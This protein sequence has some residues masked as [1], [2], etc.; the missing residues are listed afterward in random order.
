[1]SAR[2]LR[3]RLAERGLTPAGLIDDL[4]RQ[5]AQRYL[6]EDAYSLGQITYLLGYSDLP[7]LTRAVRRWTGTT[8]TKWRSE[9]RAIPPSSPPDS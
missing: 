4:R 1:M 2:T 3:R 8:P 6:A 7:T 9:L 5:L